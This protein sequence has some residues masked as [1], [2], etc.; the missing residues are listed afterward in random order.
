ML[1][2][3]SILRFPVIIFQYFIQCSTSRMNEKEIG[4]RASGTLSS[5]LDVRANA[6]P[7]KRTCAE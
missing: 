1:I 6:W 4:R 2:L 7:A 5:R 3:K